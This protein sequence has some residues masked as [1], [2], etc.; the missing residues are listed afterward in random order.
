[1]NYE[2][3]YSDR[4]EAEIRETMQWWRDNRSREQAARWIEET[5][6]AIEK[7]KDEPE[8]FPLAPESDLHPQ[9]LRQLLFGVGRSITHRVIFTIDGDAVKIV[10]V[11]HVARCE[12][13]ADDL[14]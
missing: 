7:L 6:A 12:L 9:G 2:I 13:H 8:R 4:A 11:R 10:A 1:M 3:I 14:S 5:F